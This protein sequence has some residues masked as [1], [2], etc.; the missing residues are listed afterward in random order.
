MHVSRGKHAKPSP[1]R[2]PQAIAALLLTTGGLLTGVTSAVA[3]PAPAPD[4]APEPGSAARRALAAAMSQIGT[5]YRTGGARPSG[6]DCSGLVQWAYRQAGVSLPRTA[7]GQSRV[8]T[9]VSLRDIRPG[10][11]L[12]YY[13]GVGHVAIA[14]GDGMLVESS[15][16][17][18]PVARRRIYT[19][20]L[21]LI[22]RVA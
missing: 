18:H 3:A 5:Q 22:R 15:Q 19:H 7:A 4:S 17:G 21:Q 1:R 6:F 13:A 20:G 10:D 11:L 2:F 16:S 14:A 12:F 9:R 8:G